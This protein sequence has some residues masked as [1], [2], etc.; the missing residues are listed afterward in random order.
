MKT[1]LTF[2]CSDAIASPT[3]IPG[4][5]ALSLCL[6]ELEREAEELGAVLAAALIGAA[7]LELLGQGR[8]FD[9]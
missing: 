4:A 9:D 1:S 8:K 6:G 5:R 3:A 2:L 7:R